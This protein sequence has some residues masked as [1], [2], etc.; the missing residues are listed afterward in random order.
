MPERAT[1]AQVVQVGVEVTE[2]TIVPA[3]KRFSA[4]SLNIGPE[5]AF[6]DPFV[7][8]GGK[9]PTVVMPMQDWAQGDIEGLLTYNELPYLLSTLLTSTTP[10]TA[11]GATTWHYTPASFG[12]DTPVSLTVERGDANIAERVAGFRTNEL[13]LD[14]S[15]EDGNSVTGAGFG[16]QFATGATLTPAATSIPTAPVMP[17][18]I[19]IYAD[20]TGA[21][22][23]TTKLLRV[24][25]ASISFSDRFNP[26]WALDCAQDSF[27]ATVETAPTAAVDF[28][29]EADAAGMALLGT[30]RTG[31][32]KFLRITAPGIVIGAGPATYDFKFDCAGIIS[33]IGDIEDRDGVQAISYTFTI[34]HDATWTKAMDVTVVNTLAAL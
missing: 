12:A 5:L 13:T 32:T 20:N 10:T 23:G 8:A 34:V 7:P 17:A 1:A 30:A 25:E 33:E 4:L 18:D 2:G 19:C 11:L 31:A 3:L 16:R 28:T 14:L 24:F 21:T 15:R 6:S 9:Y 26:V 22:I 29:M 27:V